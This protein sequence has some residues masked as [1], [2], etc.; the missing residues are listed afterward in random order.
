M[1]RAPWEKP[2]GD[3]HV[4]SSMCQGQENGTPDVKMLRQNQCVWRSSLGKRTR[5]KGG[6]GQGPGRARLR[7]GMETSY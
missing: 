6:G 5:M 1:R 3:I 7:L 4:E 2:C